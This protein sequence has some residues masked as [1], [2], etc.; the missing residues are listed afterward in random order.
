M[1]DPL[2]ISAERRMSEGQSVHNLAQGLF[3]GGELARTEGSFDVAD[4]IQMT[5]KFIDA[6]TEVLFEAAIVSDDILTFADI[7]ER[8][9]DAWTLYEVKSTND[10]KEDHQ[11]DVAIQ[12]YAL[13]EAGFSVSEAYLLHLNREYIRDGDLDIDDLFQRVPLLEIIEPLLTQI[14]PEIVHMEDVIKSNEEPEIDIG[15]YCDDPNPCDFKGYCWAHVPEISVFNVCDEPL[16]LQGH[17]HHPCQGTG[18]K[19]ARLPRHHALQS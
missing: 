8:N 17:D 6:K 15:P 13:R 18:L 9:G 4:S 10:I 5:Q 14:P 7:L 12:V 2:D 11:W 16:C 3:P 19:A 1:R